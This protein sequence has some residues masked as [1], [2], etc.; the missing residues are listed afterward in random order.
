MD[1]F[2]IVE[3]FR[4][5][6]EGTY[7]WVQMEEKKHEFL[8]LIRNVTYSP[9]KMSTISME[10][11]EFGNITLNM[12]SKGHKIKFKYPKTGVFQYGKHAHFFRRIPA[13]RYRRGLCT[14]NSQIETVTHHIIDEYE[15]SLTSYKVAAAFL[16][17][18]YDKDFALRELEKSFFCS[19]ALKDNFALVKTFVNNPDHFLFH[20]TNP[21]ARV[22]KDGLITQLYTR[23][24]RNLLDQQGW[25][26]A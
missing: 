4:R 25:E 11:M 1:Y 24:Y 15:P 3:D 12:G 2:E 7:V 22:S 9:S 23:T 5:R 19:I 20:W 16:P 26:Y 6:W 10:S 21:V 14:D 18:V 13:L 17:V 8:A